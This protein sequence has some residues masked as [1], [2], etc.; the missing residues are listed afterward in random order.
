MPTYIEKHMVTTKDTLNVNHD[1][2]E[3]FQHVKFMNP[4]NIYAGT[5]TSKVYKFEDAISK[6]MYDVVLSSGIAI[7]SC[8]D[9][10]VA[11]V[12]AD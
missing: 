1:S 9:K 6:K 8:E 3:T 4:D 5:F 12:N 7:L 11:V 10:T 2:R